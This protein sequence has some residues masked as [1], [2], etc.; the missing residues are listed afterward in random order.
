LVDESASIAGR[1]N[2]LFFWVIWIIV[3]SKRKSAA[4]GLSGTTTI[5]K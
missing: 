1:K 2:G 4:L 5:E 3:E